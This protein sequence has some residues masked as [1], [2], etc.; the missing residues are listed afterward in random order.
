MTVEL[1]RSVSV[2]KIGASGLEIVV[3]ASPDE[4]AAVAVRMGLPGIESI[5]C[6][7]RLKREGGGGKIRARGDLTAKVTHICIVSAEDF[8]A[9]VHDKFTVLFVPS[10]ME[11]DDPDPD[12]EDE[13]PYQGGTIDLGEAAT[14]QLAL[15]LDPY[16]RMPGAE[17]LV[18][19]EDD[20]GV[21]D[22]PGHD[23]D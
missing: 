7:Y 6:A 3:R 14:E 4:C 18:F 1:S 13:I 20:D 23:A 16:P 10:G 17:A 8:D 19:L 9:A 5:E 15:A 21:R 11:H 22:E 12:R 2:S